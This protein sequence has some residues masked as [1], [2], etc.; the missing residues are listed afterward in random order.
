MKLK[1]PS[2]NLFLGCISILIINS[3]FISNVVAEQLPKVEL[4]TEIKKGRFLIGLRQYI[5]GENDIFS[6]KKN[7]NFITDK[8]FLKLISSNGVKHKSK[9]IDITWANIPIKNPQK[10]ER[11]VFGPFASYES[12]KK[13][14]EK[15]QE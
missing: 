1:F 14:A 15:L 4:K 2:L 12:A 8:G 9:Q 11:I 3:K 10:I 13:Q 5:G 6:K 7:I